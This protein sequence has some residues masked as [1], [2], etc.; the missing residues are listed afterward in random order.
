MTANDDISRQLSGTEIP[1]TKTMIL[2]KKIDDLLK[3]REE[4]EVC[5]NPY[6]DR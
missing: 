5:R 2:F 4:I 1:D 3:K 6:G